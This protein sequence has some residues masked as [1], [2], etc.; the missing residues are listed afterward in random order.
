MEVNLLKLNPKEILEK[1]KTE[2]FDQ[3][4]N[5]SSDLM[6]NEGGRLELSG[7]GAAHPIQDLIQRMR[8]SF[9][10]LGFDEVTTPIIVEE[11]EIFKQYGPEASVILDRCYYL[12]AIPRPDIG[13]S[14]EKCEKIRE[15]GVTLDSVRVGKLQGVL[16]NYKKGKIDSDDFV[17]RIGE[18]LKIT[19]DKAIRVLSEVFPEFKDL[20]A[21]SSTLTL[22]SHLTSSWFETL[23]ALN[24]KRSLPLK[25]F[26][27]GVRFRRE[28]SEDATHLRTHNGASC[29]VMDKAIT[30]DDGKRIAEAFFRDF[31]LNELKFIKKKT[32]S[33]YYLPQTELEVFTCLP[34]TRLWVE[35]ADLGLYSPIALAH[36]NIE[37]PVLNLGVGVERTGMI[38]FNEVDIRKLVYPQ[39]YAEWNLSDEQLVNMIRI[40]VEPKTVFGLGIRDAIVKTAIKEAEENSPC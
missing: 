32:T 6:Q 37:Y 15:L 38:L 25:L 13:L 2:G 27:V 4:W 21:I 20:K 35:I 10:N 24:H 29:V 36:Y 17:E 39:F 33:K 9:L 23:N 30:I 5:K 11:G 14:N 16:R 26:S 8:Q 40:S 22:R 34:N 31:S 3:V 18:A 19:D 28:Q 1:V 7:R 12:A